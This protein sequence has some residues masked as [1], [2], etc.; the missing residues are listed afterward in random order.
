MNRTHGYLGSLGLLLALGLVGCGETQA[1]EI[2]IGIS[3]NMSLPK[4]VSAIRIQVLAHGEH[5]H[6][7][8]YNVGPGEDRQKLPGSLAVIQGEDAT[9]PVTMKVIALQGADRTA[10]IV[11]KAISTVPDERIAYLNLPVDWLCDG[12]PRSTGDAIDPDYEPECGDGMTCVAGACVTSTVDE[13]SLDDYEPGALFGGGT[14]EGDGTCF[15]TQPC[16]AEGATPTLSLGDCT[17]DAPAGSLNVAVRTTGDGICG[18]SGCLVPL[19][20]SDKGAGWSESG[21]KVRLPAKVCA[22]VQEGKALG[23]TVSTACATKTSSTPTCGPWSSVGGND[24]ADIGLATLATA[25]EH[26]VAIAVAA[27]RVY[28]LNSGVTVAGEAESTEGGQLQSTALLGGIPK[29]HKD[30]L[31]SPRELISVGSTLFLTTYGPSG[32]DTQGGIWRFDGTELTSFLGGLN[33]PEGITA[34]RTGDPKK[35]TVHY[36]SFTGGTVQ[37]YIEDAPAPTDVVNQPQNY[38]IRIATSPDRKYLV[39]LNE[40]QFGAADGSV[41]AIVEGTHVVL[42]PNQD[43]P[44]ALAVDDKGVCWTTLGHE[45]LNGQGAVHCLPFGA[46]QAGEGATTQPVSVMGQS[47]PLG[48]AVDGDMVY[49]TNRGDGTVRR[50]PRAGGAQPLEGAKNQHKPG[51]LT[52]DEGVLYWVNEGELDNATGSVMSLPTASASWVVAA[53]GGTDVGKPKP[54]QDVPDGGTEP[55]PDGGGGAFEKP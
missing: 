55:A 48:I 16:F 22:L 9:T 14:G 29:L 26:P 10:R 13:T 12:T 11:A 18:A 31:A 44:R 54:P 27:G 32:G 8:V 37:R 24:G 3:T 33:T 52:L 47:F 4:D 25:Q 17:F 2:M 34:Y 30:K 5:L 46:A 7:K 53:S 38:P 50:M 21:G 6:D 28:W 15:D 1:G 20:R 36:T 41:Q 42:A 49:W 19:D 43:T 35:W 51:A 23:V 40:G 39:W 45:G